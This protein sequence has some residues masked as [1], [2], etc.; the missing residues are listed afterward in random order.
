MDLALTYIINGTKYN[1]CG[2]VYF[3][4]EKKYGRKYYVNCFNS[5][6]ACVLRYVIYLH[7]KTAVHNAESTSYTV[8]CEQNVVL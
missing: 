7:D 8:Q 3:D 2:H 6:A 5:C 1:M 4:D